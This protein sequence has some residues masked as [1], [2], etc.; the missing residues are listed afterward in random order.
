MRLLGG[1]TYPSKISLCVV[2]LLVFSGVVDE[3]ESAATATSEL[4]LES[5]DGDLV[6]G[7]L[8]SLDK[9]LSDGLLFHVGH[10]WV[11][12]LD[13]LVRHRVSQS[14]G[15]HLLAAFCRGGGS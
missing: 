14:V 3:G 4:G 7:G 1:D 13:G 12:H 2:F 15:A 9:L 10:L 11:D 6:S 8:E 5:E